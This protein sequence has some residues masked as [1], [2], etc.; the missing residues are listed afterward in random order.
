VRRKLP[1]LSGLVRAALHLFAVSALSVGAASA[2]APPPQRDVFDL[3]A[4]LL[5]KPPATGASAEP[6]APGRFVVMAIPVI[7]ADPAYGAIFGAG[8][9]AAMRRGPI[10]T[11]QLSSGW[12]TATYSTKG[13]LNV[14]VPTT[15][16]AAANR[17]AFVGDWRFKT[18]HQPTY[19]LGALRPAGDS[20]DM[21]FK[22]VRFYET[23]YARVARSLFAGV[24]YQF[25]RHF[26]IRDRAAAA[27]L[28]SPF[29]TYNGDRDLTTTTSSGVALSVL[30][31]SRDSPAFPTRGFYASASAEL[32]PRWLGSDA[33]WQAVRFEARAYP[34]LQRDGRTILAL[35]TYNWL[36]FG[37]APYLDLPAVG[38]NRSSNTARGYV[39]GR[40]RAPRQLYGE[41]E[42]RRQLTSDG[43]LSG[44]VFVNGMASS[45]P[46]TGRFA[47]LDP[48][49][50]FGLR[51]KLDKRTATNITADFGFGRGG[52]MNFYLNAGEV[53]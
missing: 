50:G 53:F 40:I 29:R 2:Q 19:G 27:S 30:H 33:A 6:L 49:Y 25:D 7:A 51:L 41:I 35:W 42:L 9:N 18:V 46:A 24:G 8:L 31:E 38:W 1:F 4:R 22:A 12:F 11:T 21:E 37:R 45:D 47:A 36:T 3:I 10:A 39:Q 23:A 52:G 34:R 44:V 28:P 16:Y 26:A 14:E 32:Y 5:G 13:Q 17:F 15:W 20:A 48:G 43:L